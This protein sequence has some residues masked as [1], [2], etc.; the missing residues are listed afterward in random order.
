LCIIARRFV[1]SV[2]RSWGTGL[3]A[4]KFIERERRWCLSFDWGRGVVA[5]RIA[6]LLCKQPKSDPIDIASERSQCGI[7]MRC[8]RYIRCVV[9]FAFAQKWL[10]AC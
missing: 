5:G 3:S 8:S 7:A 6:R 10:T 2:W 9:K 4:G 1:I